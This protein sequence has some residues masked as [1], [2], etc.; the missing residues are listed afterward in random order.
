MKTIPL[1][2]DLLKSMTAALEQSP[3]FQGLPADALGE[4]ASHAVLLQLEPG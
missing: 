3:L 2:G 4:I 1:E